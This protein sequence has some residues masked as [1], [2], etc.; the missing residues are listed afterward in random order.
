MEFIELLDEGASIENIIPDDNFK[1][2]TA[3]YCEFKRTPM[4]NSVSHVN[5]T[6]C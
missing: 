5:K 4:G 2:V 6:H 1:V 3:K